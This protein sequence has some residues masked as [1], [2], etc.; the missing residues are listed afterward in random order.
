MK[1]K[2]VGKKDANT[3]TTL[4]C[5][6]EEEIEVLGVKPLCHPQ[7]GNQSI[8]QSVGIHGLARDPLSLIYSL[9]LSPPNSYSN[10]ASWNHVLSSSP[11]PT[12][13]SL[14][15]LHPQL[16]PMLPSNTKISLNTL[17][18]CGKCLDYQ[19]LNGIEMER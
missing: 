10:K 19:P 15:H 3:K 14:L 7:S 5:V 12:T 13:S 1:G 18:G 11:D 6:I 8:R 4:W 17:K 2:R 16:L 9:Y